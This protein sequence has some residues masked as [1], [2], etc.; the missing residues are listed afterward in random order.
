[1]AA[2]TS[3]K[4]GKKKKTKE[5]TPEQKHK[6]E[7]RA[8]AKSVQSVFDR[9]GFVRCSELSDIEIEFD[10]RKGDFDDAF[11]HEN[12]LVFVEY[13]VSNQSQVGVRSASHFLK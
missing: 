7:K 10:G 8:F 13:T 4:P 1:M 3:K 11:V 2:S 12:V 5:L 6:A 9:I